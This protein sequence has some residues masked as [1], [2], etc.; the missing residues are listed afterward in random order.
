MAMLTTTYGRIAY[1]FYPACYFNPLISLW[2]IRKNLN[3]SEQ[4]NLKGNPENAV[5]DFK[6]PDT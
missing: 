5:Q 6:R 4:G 1:R 3:K 2:K